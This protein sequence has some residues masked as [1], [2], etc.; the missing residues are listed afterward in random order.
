MIFNNKKRPC[1]VIVDCDPGV[2][3][4]LALA[5]AWVS[6]ELEVLGVTTVGGNVPLSAGYRNVRR[7]KAFFGAHMQDGGSSLPPVFAGAAK[8]LYPRRL[9]RGV[10]YAIH[11]EDGLGALFARGRRPHRLPG[12]PG[13]SAIRFIAAQA[14]KWGRALTIVALG[15]LT[16]LALAARR[17]PRAIAGVGRIVLMGGTAQMPGNATPAAEFNIHCDPESAHVVFHCGASITMVGLD[18]TRRVLLPAKEFRGGGPFRKAVRGLVRPYL[19]YSKRF[20]KVDGITLHDPLALAVAIDPGLVR[21]LRRAVVEVVCVKGPALGMTVVDLRSNPP[22]SR[23]QRTE[24]AL[25][26]DRNRFFALFLSR[27]ERYRGW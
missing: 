13:E 17:D 21:C 26:V 6:P 4:A 15:P 14:K 22:A 16:N 11:G 18:V 1:R 5:M 24:V 20:R 25:E 12:E 19:R 7:L 10:S 8:P 2:D 27:L 9:D 3:D 23:R